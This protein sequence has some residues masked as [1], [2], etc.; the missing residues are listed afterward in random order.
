MPLICTL[1]PTCSPATAEQRIL[2][3]VA[4]LEDEN[5]FEPGVL[6]VWALHAVS[7]WVG[8]VL[9]DGGRGRECI[10]VCISALETLGKKLGLDKKLT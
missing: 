10:C 5:E 1:C 6:G 9:E 8:E 2:A 7:V 4:K 3:V